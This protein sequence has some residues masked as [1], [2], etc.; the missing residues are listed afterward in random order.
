M[1]DPFSTAASIAEPATL[2]DILLNKTLKYIKAMK[3]A[4]DETKSWYD[5]L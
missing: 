3:E 1:R 5:V 4:E 2:A